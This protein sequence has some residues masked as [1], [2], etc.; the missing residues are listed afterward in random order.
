MNTAIDQIRQ[1]IDI[2]DLI[3][4]YITLKKNGRNF[5]AVCPFH[6][7]KTPSFVVSP[8]RQIW[9]CFG[10]CQAGG[11]IFGFLMRWENITFYEAAQELARRTGVVLQPGTVP[12]EHWK[13]KEHFFTINSL[14]AQYFQYILNKTKFGE[15]AK[16]YLTQR[17]I[18][19]EIAEHF[20]LGYAPDSWDSLQ[21]YL[22]KK[23]YE[24][25]DLVT[26]GLLIKS[27]KGSY[28]DRFRGRLIFPLRDSR[29]NIMGFSGRSLDAYEKAAKYINSPETPIYHKRETLFGIDIAREGIKKQK[30][31]VVVEGEFDVIMPYQHGFENFVAIKGTALTREQIALLKRYTER[32]NL[33]L[34]SDAAGIEAMKRGVSAAEGLD[35]ELSVLLIDGA[36]D[37]DEA[38]RQDLTSFKKT[39]AKPIP[40]YDFL[41][42]EVQKQY[43]ESTAFNKKKI[44]QEMI[45]YINMIVNP[46]VQEY[47]LNKLAQVI[48]LS[49][50]TLELSLRLFR[51]TR[52]VEIPDSSIKEKSLNI[53]RKSILEKYAISL[54]LQNDDL[55]ATSNIFFAALSENDFEQPALRKII[56]LLKKY[57]NDKDKTDINSF[58]NILP[59]ELQATA[60]EL[61]LYA[62]QDLP[63]IKSDFQR[64][65]WEIKKI[66]LKE[67]LK[68]IA[69]IDSDDQEK[70]EIEMLKITNELQAVEKTLSTL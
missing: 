4:S 55:N 40:V 26:A 3:G 7:E 52:K 62:S 13:K 38:I 61:F 47:Y 36:K 49:E 19:L 16:D 68:Q 41:I 23:N 31:V 43:P 51:K 5:K 9:H 14:A 46:V 18:K 45:P 42:N 22:Y 32:I 6:Q 54:L 60:N 66:N 69:T 15:K 70:N 29:G 2:V 11:D 25:E 44:S 30:S 63:S 39:L 35:V 17:G 28:Y 50:K 65:I 67:K 10:G 33:A 48:N 27:E 59:K 1:K 37:P 58:I 53:P 24:Q 20:G 8:E 57:M 21:K 56:I 12:D 64:T 34:D